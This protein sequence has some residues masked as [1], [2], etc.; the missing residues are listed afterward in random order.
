MGDTPAVDFKPGDLIACGKGVAFAIAFTGGLVVEQVDFVVARQAFA[1]GA[2]NQQAVAGFVGRGV[3]ER[4][5]TP[6]QVDLVLLRGLGERGLQDACAVG[7]GVGEFVGIA[8]SHN[9]PVF[10]QQHPVC[11]CGGGLGDKFLHGGDVVGDAGGA[12]ELD[13]GEGEGGHE[14]DS[15]DKAA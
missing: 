12:G 14:G 3:G 15:C 13:G 4:D 8:Q 11:A 9:R 5:G 1:I 6:E 2:V 10:G 7:F